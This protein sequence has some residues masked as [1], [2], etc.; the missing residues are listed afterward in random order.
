MKYNF[1][2]ILECQ[3]EHGGGTMHIHIIINNKE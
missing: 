3:W 2:S 1:I